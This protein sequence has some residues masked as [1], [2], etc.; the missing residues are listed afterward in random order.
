MHLRTTGLLGALVAAGVVLGAVVGVGGGRGVAS[1]RSPRQPTPPISARAFAFEH[2]GR[3]PRDGDGLIPNVR[4]PAGTRAGPVRPCDAIERAAAGATTTKVN[5]LIARVENT[6]TRRYVICLEGVF[7]DPIRVWSKWTE[8]LLVL[9]ARPGSSAALRLGAVAPSEVDPNDHD[10]GVVGGVDLTDSRDVEV[11]GLSIS[12]YHSNG[13]DY[14]PTGILATVRAGPVRSGGKAPHESACFARSRDHACSGIYLIDDHISR[15][16]N[17]ADETASRKDCGNSNVGAYGIAVLSYGHNGAR[18]L[19][20][21]VVEGDTVDHTRTGQ[22]ETVTINGDVI[23]F[24]LAHDRV[25]DTDNIALDSIGWEEGTDQARHG[26][27]ADNVVADVDTYGNDSYGSFSHGRCAQQQENAA[28]IYDDG[29]SYIWITGNTVAETDQGIEAD[30]ETPER[31]TDHILV[32]KN[33]VSDGAGTSLGDPSRG[34]NPAGIRGRSSVAGHAY[35]A[36]YVDAYGTGSVV[37]DVYAADNTFRNESQHYGATSV[38]TAPVVDVAGLY[39]TIVLWD[40]TVL[41]GGRTDRVNP[42]FEIDNRPRTRYPDIF[43]CTSYED[44]S[45]ESS[46]AGNFVDPV[47]SFL[48]LSSWKAH[49]GH[50]YDSR[51]AV[52]PARCGRA[53]T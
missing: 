30:V 6:I 12:G 3:T 34:P 4:T 2:V 42:L 29:G 7:R 27:I 36:F 16:V 38:Q 32:T 11:E 53:R 1:G 50:G 18:A 41:G 10:G 8:A 19:Q 13:P 33:H 25:Y 46:G 28:G 52:G 31:V 26:V 17:L 35:D 49:N 48:S 37:E 40:N 47:S 45:A 44:L 23:D 20:H 39:R 14:T 43:N 5:S 9:E 24:L 51:S 22:S 21:V 15:I